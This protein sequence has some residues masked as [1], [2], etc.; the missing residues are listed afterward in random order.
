M[1]G[2]G[3]VGLVGVVMVLVGPVLIVIHPDHFR[4]TL[5]SLAYR[6]VCLSNDHS[7]SQ[8]RHLKKN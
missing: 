8:H 4:F 3:P 1:A 5:S 2:L 7:H 6:S